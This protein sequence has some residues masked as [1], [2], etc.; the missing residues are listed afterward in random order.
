MELFLEYGIPGTPVNRLSELATDPHFTGRDN[1]YDSE[2]RGRK[3]RL[4]STP[5]KTPEQPF[6]PSPVPELWADTETVLGRVLG[7]SADE[8]RGL[9]TGQAVLTRAPGN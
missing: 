6:Q 8:I 7:L 3:L 2:Y 1:I 4:T 5:I 9:A